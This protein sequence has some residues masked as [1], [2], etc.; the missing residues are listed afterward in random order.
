MNIFMMI[1][2]LFEPEKNMNV[3]KPVTFFY[4]KNP[5]FF[6]TRL[7]HALEERWHQPKIMDG[8]GQLKGTV[9]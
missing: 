8:N 4:F 7:Q 1:I 3:H 9:A 5:D 2:I 6:Q